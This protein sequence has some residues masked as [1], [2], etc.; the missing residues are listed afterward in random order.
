[1]TEVRIGHALAP[2]EVARRVA[3][4]AQRHSVEHTPEPGGR[5]GRL[6]LETPFGPVE[7]RYRVETDALVVALTARP[8]FLPEGLVRRALEDKLAPELAG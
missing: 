6:A 8:P 4:L 5:A 1:M 7:A 3:A 2:A